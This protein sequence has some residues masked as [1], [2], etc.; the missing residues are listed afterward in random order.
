MTL[1]TNYLE[2]RSGNSRRAEHIRNVFWIFLLSLE[3]TSIHFQIFSLPAVVGFLHSLFSSLIQDQMNIIAFNI[4]VHSR[5]EPWL[6]ATNG[7]SK[8]LL[9]DILEACCV[10]FLFFSTTGTFTWRWSTNLRMPLCGLC[11]SINDF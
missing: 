3:F 2:D 9:E 11:V 5:V 10:C 6:P 8:Q 1:C 7:H 4:F